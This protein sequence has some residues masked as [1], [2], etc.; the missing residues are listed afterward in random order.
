MRLLKS[1]WI[2]GYANTRRELRD[3][4]EVRALILAVNV[5]ASWTKPVQ[6]C[7]RQSLALGRTRTNCHTFLAIKHEAF[8]H[9]GVEKGTRNIARRTRLRKVTVLLRWSGTLYLFLTAR[10]L[11]RMPAALSS[12]QHLHAFYVTVEFLVGSGV[13]VRLGSEKLPRSKQN[14]R[15]RCETPCKR[16]RCQRRRV[17]EKRIYSKTTFRVTYKKSKISDRHSP[18]SQIKD[19]LPRCQQS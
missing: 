8:D 3:A 6:G 2:E 9:Y 4:I 19:L 12:I 10:N 18:G 17:L 13:Q 15:M 14:P 5:F 1:H 11:L 16:S 7:S